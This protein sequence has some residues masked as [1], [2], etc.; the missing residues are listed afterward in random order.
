MNMKLT[1]L[2][3]AV[4]A[5]LLAV[6]GKAQKVS[7]DIPYRFATRAEAQM[8]I[9]D[10]DQYTNSWNQFDINARLQ[11]LNGRKSQL[12][13]LAMESTREWG[14]ADRSKLNKAFMAVEAAIKKQKLK[15]PFP[16]EV[17]LLKTSMAEEGGAAAY[18]RENW[19]AIGE[20]VLEKASDD[21]L[22]RLIAHELFHLLTRAD[23]A[24]KKKVYS[25]IGFNVLDRPIVFPA[26]LMQKLI[27]NPDVSCHDSYAP[28]TIDGKSMNCAMVIY[29][30]RAYTEGSLNQYIQ[31]GLVP[32]NEQ[33]IPYQQNGITT[34]YAPEQVSDFQERIGKNTA[35]AIDPEEVLADNFSYVLFGKA[36]LSDPQLVENLAK[37][38]Q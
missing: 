4:G 20:Q 17:I 8:L 16:S 1:H 15:L 12:L 3:F 10:I 18:T 11:S 14:D 6:A 27:S 31:I 38:M 26:D 13:T 7:A 37:A 23:V 2:L 25:V 33:F 34:I 24:F 29:T 19:I 28:F 21:D 22:A 36:D 9:T 35:Y 32:L 5:L 30:D